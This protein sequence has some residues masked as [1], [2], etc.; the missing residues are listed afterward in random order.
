MSRLHKF[1]TA[2]LDLFG[3]FA[4]A[5]RDRWS[6]LTVTILGICVPA[7]AMAWF[8]D[9]FDHIAYNITVTILVTA[10]PV[11]ELK[12]PPEPLTIKNPYCWLAAFSVIVLILFI[13]DEFDSQLITFNVTLFVL[14]IPYGLVYVL[15]VRSEWLVSVGLLL[16]LLAA[17]IYW[18]A[19]LAMNNASF[20]FL[21][22]PLPIILAGSVLWAPL[23]SRILKSARR[24]KNRRISGPGTQALAM[25]M[26]FFPVTL[27]AVAIPTDLG[28]SAM[29]SNVSLALIGIL[30]S[31]VISEP[32]RR[33]F[34]EWGRLA[35][36]KR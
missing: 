22:L 26:L 14:A 18:I 24:R 34:I 27:V 8:L 31:A 30:L 6:V 7:Y 29:W 19:G 20:D 23:A 12:S 32:L 15:V 5:V 9:V 1:V 11:I 16:A 25:T 10:L 2:T 35:P 4:C 28:L 3:K 33:F 36:Y 17:M 21:L 13:G